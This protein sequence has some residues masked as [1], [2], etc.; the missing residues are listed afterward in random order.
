MTTGGSREHLGSRPPKAQSGPFAPPPE[1]HG[2]LVWILLQHLIFFYRYERCHKSLALPDF[3]YIILFFS[4]FLRSKFQNCLRNSKIFLQLDA[5][6]SIIDS[7]PTEIHKKRTFFFY[8]KNINFGHIFDDFGDLPCRWQSDISSFFET[9]F[10]LLPK[11]SGLSL[12]CFQFWGTWLRL[13]Q[14]TPSPPKKSVTPLNQW[15]MVYSSCL[16]N[17]S[18]HTYWSIWH[19]YTKL[20][21][22]QANMWK[23]GINSG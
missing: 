23:L 6:A 2:R 15:T 21:W 10:W 17:T 12:R 11:N 7:K 22:F 8:I 3:L 14:V 19:P 18:A 13:R 1:K 4:V 5:Y 20:R 9:E 16:H